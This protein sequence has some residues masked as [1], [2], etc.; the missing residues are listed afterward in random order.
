MEEKGVQELCRQIA[1]DSSAQAADVLRKAE[2]KVSARLKEAREAATRAAAETLAGAERD[3]ERDMKR[4]VSKAQLDAR[5]TGLLGSEALITEVVKRVGARISKLRNAPEYA[6]V[7]KRL[8]LDGVT[9][10]GE[11]EVDL[12][13]AEEDRGLLTPAFMRQIGDELARRG[14]AGPGLALS[15][16]TIRETGVVVRSR[17]GKVEI[18]NTLEGRIGRMSRE[19]RA[20]IAREIFGE[21]KTA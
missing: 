12:M 1:A 5:K 3:A 4:A 6:G 20:L 21:D 14:I 19:L 18:R 7:L 2:E 9:H 16:E 8:I 10:L 15:K 11:K 17:T 13:V